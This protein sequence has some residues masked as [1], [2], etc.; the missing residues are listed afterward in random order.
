[1]G[2]R[3]LCGG[4]RP[5]SS[6]SLTSKQLQKSFSF[7]AIFLRSKISKVSSSAVMVA[8]ICGGGGGEKSKSGLSSPPCPDLQCPRSEEDAWVP[9]APLQQLGASLPP[10]PAQRQNSA[11]Q[12]RVPV[13]SREASSHNQGG[14]HNPC[15]TLP[16]SPHLDVLLGLRLLLLQVHGADE[17]A[18]M[19]GRSE[20]GAALGRLL[21]RDP[22][23]QC[24]PQAPP[25]HSGAPLDS[26]G[27]QV[28]QGRTREPPS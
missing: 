25:T 2:G 14:T 8:G 27:R 4:H 5:A 13:P 24:P 15:P 3:E 9:S 20:K 1:M 7:M 18:G 19:L 28:G 22:S 12:P 10:P 23:G 21:Q 26:H 16:R 6:R 11:C 17:V